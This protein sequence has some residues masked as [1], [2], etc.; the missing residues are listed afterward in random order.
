MDADAGVNGMVEYFVVPGN[1]DNLGT[2]SG[3]GKDRINVVDGYG[4]FTIPLPHQ[5][6]VTVNRSLD[7]ERIQR[8]L[9][10]IVASVSQF[11]SFSRG[12]APLLTY[13]GSKLYAKS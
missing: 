1:G 10:T 4:F 6:G 11:D 13:Q 12:R 7:Y 3:I 5:G 9:V 8:Y 2:T